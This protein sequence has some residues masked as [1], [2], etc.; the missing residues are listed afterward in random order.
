MHIC[1][2]LEYMPANTPAY[3]PTCLAAQQPITWYVYEGRRWGKGGGESARARALSRRAEEER[4][5]DKG[6]TTRQRTKTARPV[7]HGTNQ[8]LVLH[9]RLLCCKLLSS[10]HLLNLFLMTLGVVYAGISVDTCSQTR[11]RRVPV[12]PLRHLRL[13][14][15]RLGLGGGMQGGGMQRHSTT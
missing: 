9:A 4:R 10:L 1:S 2:K 3:L 5:R 13:R 14:R 8:S 7:G 12:C 11:V 15:R 6:H